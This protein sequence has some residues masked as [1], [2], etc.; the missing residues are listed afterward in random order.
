MCLQG[1]LLAPSGDG[2]LIHDTMQVPQRHH[3]EGR[4]RVVAAPPSPI[5]LH[6]NTPCSQSPFQLLLSSGCLLLLTQISFC[7]LMH[8]ILYPS[9]SCTPNTTKP[10][11]CQGRKR[12]SSQRFYHLYKCFVSFHFLRN[13]NWRYLYAS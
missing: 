7:Y 4:Q 12:I 1:W 11:A 2:Q 6:C 9:A 10:Q 8:S 3:C 5:L 13:S